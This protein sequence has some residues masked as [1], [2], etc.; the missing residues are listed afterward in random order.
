MKG[1]QQV[2]ERII[3]LQHRK[4][5]L[6][7]EMNLLEKRKLWDFYDSLTSRQSISLIPCQVW[8]EVSITQDTKDWKLSHKDYREEYYTNPEEVKVKFRYN[9]DKGCFEEAPQCDLFFQY[10]IFVL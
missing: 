3:Y 5:C 9:S 7:E 8:S 6:E 10:C 1:K 2:I 4:H